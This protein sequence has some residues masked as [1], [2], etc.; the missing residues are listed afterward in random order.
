MA[1]SAAQ[2]PKKARRESGRG[3]AG[4]AGMAGLI[5]AGLIMAGI[6]LFVFIEQKKTKGT[7]KTFHF[8]CLL[9]LPSLLLFPSVQNN[10]S[11]CLTTDGHR[12]TQIKTS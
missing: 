2:S 6:C 5:M 9:C 7:K 8:I 11:V 3:A 4:M 12:W 10:G 1:E